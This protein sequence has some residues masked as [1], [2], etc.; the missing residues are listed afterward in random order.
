MKLR[1]VFSNDTGHKYKCVIFFNLYQVLHSTHTSL[2]AGIHNIY[3]LKYRHC[4]CMRYISNDA[5]LLLIHICYIYIYIFFKIYALMLIVCWLIK[6]V[7]VC[8]YYAMVAQFGGL[9]LNC[10]MQ[11]MRTTYS[12][13]RVDRASPLLIGCRQMIMPQGNRLDFGW[14]DFVAIWRCIMILIF[15]TALINDWKI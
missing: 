13:I 6:W 14:I 1:R 5:C 8:V 15:K 12:Y 7:C 2:L 9:K 11:W 4:L 10:A 3:I